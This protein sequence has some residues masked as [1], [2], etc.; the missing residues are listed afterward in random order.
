MANGVTNS[1]N[2]GIRNAYSFINMGSCILC[3]VCRYCIGG[4]HIG[5][6][7]TETRSGLQS[8]ASLYFLLFLPSILSDQI[9]L[10]LRILDHCCWHWTI[11]LRL[12][13]VSFA[14]VPL[15]F[16]LDKPTHIMEAINPS[17]PYRCWAEHSP[18][19]LLK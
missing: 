11:Y 15:T 12:S 2:H 17:L 5:M 18:N 6:A 19:H 13:L 8:C 9:L 14:H 1:H 10:L 7:Y 4:V 3:A 16:F